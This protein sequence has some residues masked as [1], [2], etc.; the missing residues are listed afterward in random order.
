MAYYDEDDGYDERPRG[1]A[2][3]FAPNSKLQGT[4]QLTVPDNYPDAQHRQTIVDLQ[5]KDGTPQV[6][7]LSLSILGERP[8]TAGV[9]VEFSPI[10]FLQLGIG[11]QAFFAEVDFIQGQMLSLAS[12]WLRVD[13]GL[14]WVPSVPAPSGVVPSQMV[15]ASVAAGVVAHA[16]K[17][18]RTRGSNNHITPGGIPYGYGPAGSWAIYTIPNF[19][20][21]FRVVANP[22]NSQCM[23]WVRG[24]GVASP[25]VAAYSLVAYPTVDLPLPSDSVEIVLV[26]LGAAD[27]ESHRVIFGLSL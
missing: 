15:G 25:P 2:G 24:Y 3:I 22:N 10:A 20:T 1:K 14:V 4:A 27:I 21:S 11:G 16:S 9:T 18:Q 17:P 6:F 12:S 23:V 19:A 13:A 8:R 26:N 7:S 5:T